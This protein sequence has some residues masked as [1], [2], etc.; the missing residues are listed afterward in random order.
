VHSFGENQ[1]RDDHRDCAANGDLQH[2]SDRG[3]DR[4]FAKLPPISSTI[5]AE[6]GATRKLGLIAAASDNGATAS[7]S[8]P[9]CEITVV[10]G[11][12]T[13]IAAA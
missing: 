1:Q 12:S 2:A 10:C 13:P 11:M 3:H 4:S 5:T 8:T 7:T 9:A 6:N